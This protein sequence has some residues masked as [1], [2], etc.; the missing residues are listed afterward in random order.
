MGLLYVC[1]T[2][3]MQWRTCKWQIMVVR[4]KLYQQVRYFQTDVSLNCASV[5]LMGV[6]LQADL[7]TRSSLCL[8]LH[9]CWSSYWTKSFYKSMTFSTIL[10]NN[11]LYFHVDCTHN[12]KV[13]S[14]WLFKINDFYTLNHTAYRIIDRM[15]WGKIKDIPYKAIFHFICSTF[16]RFLC[17]KGSTIVDM[18]QNEIIL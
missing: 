10:V 1:V 8:L 13:I 15:I 16:Y 17:K 4:R 18:L 6:I 9:I 7:L 11:V 5:T 2:A 3:R 12:L 14:M